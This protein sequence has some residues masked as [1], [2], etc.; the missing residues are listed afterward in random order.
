MNNPDHDKNVCAKD[1]YGNVTADEQGG[2]DI[3]NEMHYKG[4]TF[5]IGIQVIVWKPDDSWLG[6]FPTRIAAKY[7]VDA[8]IVKQK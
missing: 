2:N 8:D 5:D 6:K 3:R 1:C 7:A 4:Y